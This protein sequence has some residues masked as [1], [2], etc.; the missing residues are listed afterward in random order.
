MHQPD[1]ALRQRQGKSRMARILRVSVLFCGL[2]LLATATAKFFTLHDDPK[3]LYEEDP[4]LLVSWRTVMFLAASVESGIALICFLASRSR[5]AP[6]SIT[7]F[8]AMAIIYRVGLQWLGYQKPCRC[9]G[10]FAEV[11]GIQE[12]V[13]ERVLVGG[14]VFLI[15]VGCGHIFTLSIGQG[16]RMS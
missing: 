6:V 3:Y 11:V 2:L 4:V 7:W 10:S 15:L 5:I 9:M 14:L 8:A 16:R 12:S 13:L 1:L